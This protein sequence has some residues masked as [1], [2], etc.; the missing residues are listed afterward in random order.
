MA[1]ALILGE[2][3][4]SSRNQTKR[5]EGVDDKLEEL[6]SSLE[7]LNNRIDDISRDFDERWSDEK[8]KY[9]LA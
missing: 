7:R 3:Y 2:T 4:R 8:Q 1:A 5:K 6:Q 9:A